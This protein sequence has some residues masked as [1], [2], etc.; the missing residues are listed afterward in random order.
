MLWKSDSLVGRSIY[1]AGVNTNTDLLIIQ[2]VP[3]FGL[4]EATS[5]QPLMFKLI[6]CLVDFCVD[7]TIARSVFTIGV[8]SRRLFDEL[9]RYDFRF[10][11]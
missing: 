4:G 11:D 7:L 2:M 3:F 6:R 10:V 8:K 1:P 5:N 9:M